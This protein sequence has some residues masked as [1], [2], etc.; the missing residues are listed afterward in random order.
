MYIQA[1]LRPRADC[2]FSSP[3]Q[4]PIPPVPIQEGVE[5]EGGGRE[6]QAEVLKN[7]PRCRYG[8]SRPPRPLRDFALFCCIMGSNGG[9]GEITE[10]ALKRASVT[11]TGPQD[12]ACFR[13]YRPA[14][15]QRAGGE[16]GRG[17]AR[18][19]C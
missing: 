3:H 9:G 12:M 17:E 16:G 2:S 4:P 11:P 8:F 7:G 19:L 15:R 13:V 1:L 14:Q 18:A 6:G 5:G 10:K